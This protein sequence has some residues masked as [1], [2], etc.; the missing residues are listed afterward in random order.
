MTRKI[1]FNGDLKVTFFNAELT[2]VGFIDRFDQLLYVLVFH[3][4]LLFKILIRR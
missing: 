3:E 2:D 4:E 1:L